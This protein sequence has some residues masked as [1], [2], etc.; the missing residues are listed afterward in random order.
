MAR[1]WK[2]RI[3]LGVALTIV[4]AALGSQA[5]GQSAEVL[6]LNK[7]EDM[8]L[9]GNIIYAVNFGAN[10]SPTVGGVVFSPHNQCAGLAIEASAGLEGA[11]VATWWD[12][13][14]GTGDAGL[15]QLL[16]SM[17]VTWTQ[18]CEIRIDA[19][20]LVLGKRYLLQLVGY[21]PE[22]H[23]RDIDIIVEDE[24][25]VTG[26]SPFNVQGGVVGQGG[27]LVKYELTATDSVLNILMVNYQNACGL[28]GLILT[29]LAPVR[30]ADYGSGTTTE[31]VS[32]KGIWQI[33]WGQGP[34]VWSDSDGSP[35]LDPNV[36]GVLDIHATAPADVSADLLAT[37]P[38]A[39][40]LTLS[41][42]D[43][44]NGDA[45]IGTMTLSGTGFNMIEGNASRVLTDEG[46]GMFL[47]PFSPP[48]P[49]LTL[50]LDEATGVFAYIQQVDDWRLQLAGLYAA[51]LMNG[52]GLQDNIM[53]ALGGQVPLIGG[54]GQFELTGQY[55]ANES[56]RPQRFCEYGT[57]T[58]LRF[59]AG[60]G[61]WDQVWSGGPWDWHECPAAV[62]ATFLGENVSGELET[63]TAGAPMI[64]ENM[65][66]SF[67]F[68]GHM[69]LTKYNET[70]RSGVDGQILGDV[71]GTFVADMNAEHATFD[72]EG[73][74]I[75]P[76]GVTLHEAPDALIT[77]TEATGVYADIRA[78]GQ[79]AWYV[80]GTVTLARLPDVPLQDNILAA[81]QNSDL[82]LHA[83][84]EFV[85]T[86]WYY[87]D[88]Q[89]E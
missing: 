71:D 38:I 36:S 76:F 85:L 51:P 15:N 33:N 11:A 7:V 68:G 30:F 5:K 54:L 28:C 66:L 53:A 83:E 2:R 46:C 19:Q 88:A 3:V 6:A 89:E 22:T 45:V 40:T 29:E 67:D 87:R 37:L 64:D 4:L 34:W 79:W 78:A 69:S 31:L 8:D 81:L 73:N 47:A 17:A 84:E 50:T 77:V 74:I 9:S 35:L 18:P 13:T 12:S 16:N 44:G 20:G 55:E 43:K 23:G 62:N 32:G 41:A 80:N 39:G 58:A 1:M 14:P 61:L 65:V 42:R 63:T 25:I 56:K 82:I 48:G 52:V 72:A 86:G 59:G 10:G 24:E 57:G 27:F 49:E 60:G 75:M 26:L 21:E 70:N